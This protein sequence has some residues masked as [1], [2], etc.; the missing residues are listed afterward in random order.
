MVFWTAV[1]VS[2]S[3]LAEVVFWASAGML[4]YVYLGYP[5][6]LA[7]VA[8][9]YRRP[10]K[11]PGYYPTISVLIAAYNEEAHIGQKL[12]ETLA[13]AYPFDKM[14]ILLIS[15]GSADRTDEIVNSCQDPR[16]KLLRID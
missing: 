12:A 11:Q 8:P 4:M 14:A 2:I 1:P 3:F 6:L 5:T 16:V 10:N 13:L 9:F 15:D 7:L